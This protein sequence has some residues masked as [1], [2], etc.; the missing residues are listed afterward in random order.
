[1]QTYKENG[2]DLNFKVTHL[3]E[4]LDAE[5]ERGAVTIENPDITFTYQ[6]SCRLN[7]METV[8]NLPRKL[9]R[10]FSNG[11]FVEMQNNRNTALCCGNSAWIG[12]DAFSKA[13]QVKRLTQG[14]N[15]ESSVMLTSCGKCRIHLGCA[16][17]DPFSG[18]KLKMELVDL[19]QHHCRPY[20]LGINEE[21]T[22]PEHGTF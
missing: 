18:D 14:R 8:R 19:T 1:M 7:S 13:L 22:I 9:I 5:L 3:Y 12:C 2:I 21:S 15:T 6:D 17:E 20:P 10:R 4:F 16:M 11:N